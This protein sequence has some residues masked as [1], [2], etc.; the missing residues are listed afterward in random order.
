MLLSV[1]IP[2]L[3]SPILDRVLQHIGQQPGQEQIGEILVVGRDEPG[4]ISGYDKVRLVKTQ[5]P[6]S[7]PEA[8]NL[9]IGEAVYDLLLFLDSDCLP[10]AGWLQG[11]L[12]AHKAGHLVVGG[13]VLPEGENYW[14]LIYN[15]TL[16]HE[17]HATTPPGMRRFLPTLNLSIRR[18]V[19]EDVGG[20]NEGLERGEDV[21]WT[22]RMHR[23]GHGL[24]FC[25]E[26]AVFH[27]HRRTSFGTVWQDCALSGHY[28]RQIRL[29]QSDV[30]HAP[31]LLR[32]P[33]LLKLLSPLIATVVTAKIVA[34][35]PRLFMEKWL[36]WPGLYL[37][38]IAWCWGGSY[39]TL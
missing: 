16:F 34:R 36:T 14:S 35:Q 30:L 6:V 7:A 31:M 26:A 15:L 1:I 8:R 23:A 32:Y 21:E 33:F 24:Y 2:S 38:K 22:A 3:N 5:Q 13:G 19:I 37:T 11:H 12:A 28:M 29:Q 18:H 9:G 39:P 27:Q 25:P 20:L 4:L 17:F 10:Q